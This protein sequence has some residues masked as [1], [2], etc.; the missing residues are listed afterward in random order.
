PLTY[1]KDVK[2]I[3]AHS[4]EGCHREGGIGPFALSTYEQVKTQRF[5]IASVT[6]ARTMPPVLA[7]KGCADY[8]NDA[9]LTDE[10]INVLAAWADGDA[11]EGT[12]VAAGPEQEQSGLLRVDLSMPM[13]VV[14]TP[15][16]S[17][18]D[19]RC[20]VIDWPKTDSTY[21]VGFRANPGNAK[22]VHHVIAYLAG[23][24]SA[25]DFQKLDDDEPGAGYTCFG[26]ASSSGRGTGWLGAW[27]PGSMGGMYPAD[28][29]IL[30]KPGSKIILQVHYNTLGKSGDLSDQ[31]SVEVAL[32]DSVKRK[33]AYVPFTNF[34]WMFQGGMTIPAMEKDVKHTFAIDPTP[35][36]G[37]VTNGALPSGVGFKVYS[38]SAHQHLLGTSSRQELRHKDGTTECLL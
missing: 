1:E 26:G 13:P 16:K 22:V 6:Q 2:P 9:T 10:Q 19:Y 28:T 33:G 34:D 5:A 24:E 14:Y 8:D 21:V 3:L 18:D 4:C 35:Y 20:F 37:A 38:A 12:K 23:P 29:G 11:M 31:T 36:L 30:V 27:A 17:P 15:Q 32:A 7:A 25:A